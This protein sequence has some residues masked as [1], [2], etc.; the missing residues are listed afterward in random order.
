MRYSL[1]QE[2]HYFSGGSVNKGENMAKL[3]NKQIEQIFNYIE[4]NEIDRK[5]YADRTG[6][7]IAT[8]NRALRK[9]GNLRKPTINKMIKILDEK[10]KHVSVED[11]DATF[12]DMDERYTQ[13]LQEKEELE[14]EVSELQTRLETLQEL[15][16]KY[17]ERNCKDLREQKCKFTKISMGDL[18]M[19]T[20]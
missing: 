16:N 11:I 9:A 19:E 20:E 17:Q 10:K 12:S 8:L 1:K 15:V 13:Y 4:D 6:V 3:T 5:E 7:S 18:F 14:K 2:S